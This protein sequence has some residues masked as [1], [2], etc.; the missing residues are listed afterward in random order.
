MIVIDRCGICPI[1]TQDYSTISTF[2]DGHLYLVGEIAKVAVVGSAEKIVVICN[3]VHMVCSTRKGTTAL[4]ILRCMPCAGCLA[5]QWIV[6]RRSPARGSKV[7]AFW[8]RGS[9]SG[10][11]LPC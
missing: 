3:Y 8:C 5:V 4:G 10:S 9:S 2:A 6:E 1:V 7:E 11:G